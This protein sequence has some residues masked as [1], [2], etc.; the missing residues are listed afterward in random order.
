[1]SN[2]LTKSQQQEVIRALRK[3]AGTNEGKLYVLPTKGKWGVK[4]EGAKRLYRVV[5]SKKEAMTIA[6]TKAA[7][8]GS[9]MI[10]VQDIHGHITK[11]ISVE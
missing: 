5:G 10:V 3:S 8:S 6:K 11:L 1:M 9:S 4:T 7:S 2:L